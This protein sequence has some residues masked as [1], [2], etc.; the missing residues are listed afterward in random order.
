MVHYWHRK[1]KIKRSLENPERPLKCNS[2]TYK[3]WE[4]YFSIPGHENCKCFLVHLRG[5]I[6][7]MAQK[8]RFTPWANLTQ[9][10][11]HARKRA[12]LP[13]PGLLCL[14][15]VQPSNQA[16]SWS[17]FAA[18][19]EALA[20]AVQ[21]LWNKR[22]TG[23]QVRVLG[24]GPIFPTAAAGI[25]WESKET[26]NPSPLYGSKGLT[27]LFK[28]TFD[29]HLTA[30]PGSLMFT[31]A[32]CKGW[33]TAWTPVPTHLLSTFLMLTH[34]PTKFMFLKSS[35]FFPVFQIL[36][37]LLVFRNASKAWQL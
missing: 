25:R 16:L 7:C 28:K 19:W 17:F 33:E 34:V 6:A 2:L 27:L 26:C 14:Y 11:R 10:T 36:T 1:H 4:T 12:W 3:V 13:H 22:M 24:K 29:W 15:T 31:A 21:G 35:H 8:T 30:L 32:V 18:G 20:E 9:K 23:S 5:P 37:W